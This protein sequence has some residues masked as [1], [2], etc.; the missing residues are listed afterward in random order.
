MGRI[1]VLASSIVAVGMAIAHLAPGLGLWRYVPLLLIALV[2]LL[3]FRDLVVK[4]RDFVRAVLVCASSTFV[5][6]A[7]GVLG[8]ALVAGRPWQRA[9]LDTGIGW[10]LGDMVSAI[11]GLYMLAAFT[12]RAREVGLSRR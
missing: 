9:V 12:G 5:S 4:P 2:A 6:A 7:I 3:A 11:L 10:F 8:Q 1:A